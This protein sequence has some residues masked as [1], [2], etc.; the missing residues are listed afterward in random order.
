MLTIANIMLTLP[1]LEEHLYI[2]NKYN[3]FNAFN[4]KY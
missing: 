3:S 1:N 4:V 2:L